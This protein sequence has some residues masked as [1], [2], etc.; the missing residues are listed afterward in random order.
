MFCSHVLL[1][2]AFGVLTSEFSPHDFPD[3]PGF[4]M[5]IIPAAWVAATEA[6]EQNLAQ[7]LTLIAFE[8]RV[9]QVD[10]GFVCR[11]DGEAGLQVWRTTDHVRY[12]DQFRD[13]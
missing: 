10:A 6:G 3:D 7:H 4:G 5:G 8:D 1:F 9:L 11:S 2:T 12:V 13:Q